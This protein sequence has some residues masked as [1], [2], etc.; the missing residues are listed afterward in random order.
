VV[1]KALVIGGGATGMTAALGLAEQGY[2]TVLIEK[3]AALGGN[4]RRIVT[5]S[6]GQA[7]QP[8]LYDL[9]AKV[10]HNDKIE[11]LTGAK[12]KTVAG[13]VGNFV[14]DIALNGKTRSI[15]YGAA[16]LATGARESRPDEY[17]YGSDPRVLTHLDLDERLMEDPDSLEGCDSIAFI[18]CV[19]SRDPHRPYCS[20]ICCT[21]TVNAAIRFKE[22]SPHMNV[23]V[24]FRDMRTYGKREALDKKARDLGVLFIRYTLDDKPRV[25]AE[26]AGIVIRCTDPTL[27]VPLELTVDRLI[28]A[29]AVE[30]NPTH[31]LVELFKCGFNADGFLTEAHPKLRPVDMAVDGLFLCG[32][33]NYPQPLEESLAQAEAAV[34]RA[35]GILAQ[36]EL[37]LDAIKSEVTQKCDGCALCLDVCPYKALSLV[38]ES[39]SGNGHK[40]RKI[41]SDPALCKGCGICAATCPKGGVYVHGFTLDQ[42]RAQVEA[43]LRAA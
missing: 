23:F 20:R 16:V 8:W 21:H 43:A 24:L 6:K 27:Q 13:S 29:A 9:I 3:S 30:P 38:E 18:Q 11:V 2:P 42:L 28:L 32:M 39:I 5:T 41:V 34:A 15:Q 40:Q 10:R 7:V 4:A 31:A 12:I 19:G 14:S 36:K 33:G 22:A 26:K 37:Q 25:S 17:L 35:C 1:Q